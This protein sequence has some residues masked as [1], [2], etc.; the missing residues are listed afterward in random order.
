MGG[1]LSMTT[2]SHV[3]T[4]T[5]ALKYDGVFNKI[6]LSSSAIAA[7]TVN[8]LLQT[9]PNNNIF[10]GINLAAPTTLSTATPTKP[11]AAT[12]NSPTFGIANGDGCNYGGIQY[13]CFPGTYCQSFGCYW[14]PENKFC[15]DGI[16]AVIYNI[17]IICLLLLRPH[18]TFVHQIS[19]PLWVH[20]RV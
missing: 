16:F 7:G 4:V 20:P 1:Y 15:P 2:E 18:S 8:L 3:M 9:P 17:Y 12:T 19:L 14:C 6:T 13:A 5:E 10:A 11:T